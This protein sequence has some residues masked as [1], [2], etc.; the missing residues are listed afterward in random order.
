MLDT[1][2]QTPAIIGF[3]DKGKTLLVVEYHLTVF[4]PLEGMEDIIL[5]D[6]MNVTVIEVTDVVVR[7]KRD[8]ATRVFL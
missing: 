2:S 3:I 4:I 7:L 6:V 1:W 8:I 5:I